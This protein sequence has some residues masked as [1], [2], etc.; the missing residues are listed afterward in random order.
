MI[1]VLKI[2]IG[3]AQPL[4]IALAFPSLYMGNNTSVLL[5]KLINEEQERTLTCNSANA[6][7][8]RVG[9]NSP[10]FLVTN[11]LSCAC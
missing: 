8:G 11:T 10:K 1:L 7:A 6:V 9:V 4:Q 3:V 5:L 2:C